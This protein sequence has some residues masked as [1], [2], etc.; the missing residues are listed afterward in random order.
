MLNQ[1]RLSARLALAIAHLDQNWDDLPYQVRLRGS[2]DSKLV[3]TRA[4]LRQSLQPEDLAS[5]PLRL[6][7]VNQ[8][9]EA[10][11]RSAVGDADL[12]T[13][14]AYVV[15]IDSALQPDA[16]IPGR[17]G[18]L[19]S[20]HEVPPELGG[21]IWI[22][23]GPP[24][25]SRELR[26]ALEERR[27]KA[28]RRGLTSLDLYEPRLSDCLT[29]VRY[30]RVPVEWVD[31]P[32][33][34]QARFDE[35]W[36]GD[37][38]DP[39]DLEIRIGL[40]SLR[41][42]FT[43]GFQYTRRLARQKHGFRATCVGPR[44]EYF[45]RLD[46]ILEEASHPERGVHILLLPELTVDATGRERLAGQLAAMASRADR[47]PPL[48]TV[49]GSFHFRQGDE[50]DRWSNV[51]TVLDHTGRTLWRQQK[52]VPFPFQGP[53][54]PWLQ[55]CPPDLGPDESYH[56]DV[57]PGRSVA[58]ARSP[59]GWLAVAICSDLVPSS[60]GEVS[61]WARS[62][63]DWILVPSMSGTTE[64]FLEA[65]RELARAGKIVCFANAVQA[66]GGKGER[67]EGDRPPEFLDQ[68][69]WRSDL[70]AFVQS[71]VSHAFGLWFDRPDSPAGARF[72]SARIAISENDT[73]EGLI[74]DLLS[75]VDAYLT[76]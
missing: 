10:W 13:L 18:V 37:T 17:L 63:A 28:G 24:G 33:H 67:G 59:L 39:E 8:R 46:K 36:S 16:A 48:L 38:R 70:A 61:R 11:L 27:Q 20:R 25:L 6:D 14:L 69:L 56:E 71:P 47:R 4:V 66:G 22:V 34:V 31:P 62:P 52:R 23:E 5:S 72:K 58:L 3:K 49:A 19:R 1:R 42:G 60:T 35:V 73:W 32:P 15:E 26:E 7:K 2:E 75:V 30:S 54:P 76:R 50:D 44:E 64:Q 21:E 41:G 68:K 55:N 9:S 51:C 57:E 43:T 40:F 29:C 65:S 74:V 45:A 53:V 12:R